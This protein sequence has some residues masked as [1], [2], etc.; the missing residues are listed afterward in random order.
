MFLCGPELWDAYNSQHPAHPATMFYGMKS[1][2][3]HD[4]AQN[5]PQRF[6][7]KIT[8]AEWPNNQRERL[9]ALNETP[10]PIHVQHDGN[11]GVDHG[12][13]SRRSPTSALEMPSTAKQC[14]STYHPVSSPRHR[15][16]RWYNCHGHGHSR[17]SWQMHTLS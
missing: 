9:W 10:G 2:A 11:T 6:N 17:S 1:T 5:Y 7:L 8:A 12:P 16:L 13:N 4:G 14:S 15:R 3:F